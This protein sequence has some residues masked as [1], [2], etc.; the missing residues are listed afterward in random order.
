MSLHG[1][2]FEVT[3]GKGLA[4]AEIKSRAQAIQILQRRAGKI[5]SNLVQRRF[6]ADKLNQTWVIAVTEFKVGDQK[7]YLSPII[8]HF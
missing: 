3:S 7:G 2:P 1:W 6:T 5:A 4:W 8:D